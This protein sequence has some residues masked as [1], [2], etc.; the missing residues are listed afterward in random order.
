[1]IF[2]EANKM[3]NEVVHSPITIVVTV[4]TCVMMILTSGNAQSADAQHVQ[5]CKFVTLLTGQ[6]VAAR[7]EDDRADL[8]E[9]LAEYLS[10]N[11]DC[12]RSP[13]IVNAIAALLHDRNDA[14][15]W[16]GAEALA[17]IGP[18]AKSA[19]PA[20]ERALKEFR[21]PVESEFRH[22]ATY[23]LFRSG[24]SRCLEKDHRKIDP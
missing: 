16:G 7:D 14:V 24:N 4:L 12:G 2:R 13:L 15:R 17:H 9:D 6:I 20:L 11:P 19:V 5:R 18:P 3:T 23:S 8:A 1:M 21:R 10:F 22:N